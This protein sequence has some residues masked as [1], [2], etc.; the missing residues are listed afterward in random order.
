MLAYTYDSQ[1]SIHKRSH[2][3]E[4]IFNFNFCDKAFS[5]RHVFS[6]HIKAHTG[7]THSILI[8]VIL[9]KEAYGS[10]APLWQSKLIKSWLLFTNN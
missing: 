3:G 2:T 1:L 9:P 10:I 7:K 6:T 5:Q 4:K 8:F